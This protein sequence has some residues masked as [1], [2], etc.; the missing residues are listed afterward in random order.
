MVP[1][2]IFLQ[3][4]LRS[5]LCIRG[6]R[7]DVRLARGAASRQQSSDPR[8]PGAAEAATTTPARRLSGSRAGSDG[9]GGGSSRRGLRPRRMTTIVLHSCVSF[10]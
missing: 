3:D 1:E 8:R 2:I 6:S 7:W 5:T 4:K 10:A 9:A